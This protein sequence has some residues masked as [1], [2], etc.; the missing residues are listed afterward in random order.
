MR[1]P[2]EGL[3][4]VEVHPAPVEPLLPPGQTLHLE[5]GGAQPGD[6]E[7]VSPAR[8][9]PGVHPVSSWPAQVYVVVSERK[10]MSTSD[11]K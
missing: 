4:M 9:D 2:D 5:V 11:T 6:D 8:E 1:P 10:K 7:V 3:V